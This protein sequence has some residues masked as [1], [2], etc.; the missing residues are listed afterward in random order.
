MK[1]INSMTLIGTVTQDIEVRYSASGTAVA[2]MSVVTNY[3]PK[4]GDEQAEFHRCVAFGRTAEIAAEFLGKGS[5]VYIQGRLQTRS[6]EKDGITRYSTEIVINDLQFLDSKG[7]RTAPGYAAP[8]R[9]MQNDDGPG[10]G[11][12]FDNSSIPF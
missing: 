9:P 11:D 1:G 10:G 6:Y 8:S 3:K 12:D 2:N 7:D 5:K 4:N